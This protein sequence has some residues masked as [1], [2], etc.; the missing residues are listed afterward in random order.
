MLQVLAYVGRQRVKGPK[1]GGQATAEIRRAENMKR[2][3]HIC[4]AAEKLEKEGM[5]SRNIPGIL[6][7]RFSPGAKQIRNILRSNKKNQ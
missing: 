1:A 3:N 2:N 7:Q 4:E 6:A 5:S